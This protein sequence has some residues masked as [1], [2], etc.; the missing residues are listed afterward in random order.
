MVNNY[1]L[2]FKVEDQLAK[3]PQ[4]GTEKAIC[5]IVKD[6]SAKKRYKPKVSFADKLWGVIFR[7]GAEKMTGGSADIRFSVNDACGNCGICARVCPVNNIHIKDHLVFKHR[8]EGCLACIHHC[9]NKAIHMKGEKS[10][11][12][13]I[14]K[15]VAV[16]EIIASN[17]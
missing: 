14:N 12:R 11:T 4:K 7:S 3:V 1:L 2:M 17:E 9:P 15:N 16:D 6:V 13:F 10:T 8:C 5:A